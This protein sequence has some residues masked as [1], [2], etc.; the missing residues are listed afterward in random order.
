M[1]EI[2]QEHGWTPLHTPFSTPINYYSRSYIVAAI[3]PTFRDPRKNAVAR[4]IFDQLVDRCADNGWGCY[5]T[6]P[7]YQERVV[8]K[9][10]Y[11]NH[12]LLRFQ[13]KLKDSI[14]P[15]G[16]ISPGRYGIWPAKM[17]N[18]RA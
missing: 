16:I 18:N 5:R 15:N 2:F 14:D 7:A 12:A 11:N 13:E 3:V 8:S 4:S 9:Y 17:R 10:S 6:S 1:S